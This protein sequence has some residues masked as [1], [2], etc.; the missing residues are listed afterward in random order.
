VEAV[1]DGERILL[2]DN[3]RDI[4]EV[5]EAI[6]IDEGFQ[7]RVLSEV[8]SALL[9]RMVEDFAPDCVLLDGQGP[10]VYGESWLNAAWLSERDPAVPTIMFTADQPAADEA[11]DRQT[12]RSQAA[13]F[14]GVLIKPFDIDNLIDMV[15]RA[16]KQPARS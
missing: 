13:Q 14:T 10:G 5:V 8:N 4:A 2:V 7:V 6:L 15:S 12:S 16:I 1:G 11:R 9:R 3:D